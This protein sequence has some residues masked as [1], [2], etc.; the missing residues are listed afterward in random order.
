MLLQMHPVMLQTCRVACILILCLRS[1]GVFGHQSTKQNTQHALLLL[2]L[3][4]MLNEPS[5]KTRDMLPWTLVAVVELICVP[6]EAGKKFEHHH[7]L[8]GG[9]NRLLLNANYCGIV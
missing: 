5:L 6:G 7:D 1:C 4:E 8:W 2:L 3:K 9:S